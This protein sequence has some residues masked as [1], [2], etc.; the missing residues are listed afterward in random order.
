VPP[1]QARHTVS[2][3][4]RHTTSL[5]RKQPLPTAV[6]AGAL[7]G[8]LCGLSLPKADLGW[9]AWICLLPILAVV[10]CSGNDATSRRNLLLGGLTLGL[11]A[12]G[13][14]VYWIVETLG[15]Y[16]GLGPA[17]AT[18]TTC[19]LILYLALYP[20]FFT[21][22]WA[23]AWRQSQSGSGAVLPWLGA[24][25]WAILDWVQTWMLSGFPWAV[26]GTTQYRVPLISSLAAL[27]GVHGLS[28]VI[29][30]FNCGLALILVTRRQRLAG[31]FAVVAVMALICGWGASYLH[32]MSEETPDPPLRIG[33]V[34]GNI[35]QDVK[36]EPG[37]KD[38]TTEHYVD[39]SRRLARESGPIDL[40]LWPET[41]LP[42]RFDDTAHTPYRQ[43]VTQLAV[44]LDT[45]LF[46]G[47]LG[48]SAASG[49]PGLYNRAF[50]IDRHGRLAGSGDKVHL[51]PFGEYL[52]FP[53]LFD[54]M[55]G[56]TAQSGSF[57][58]GEGHAVISLAN[59]NPD[60]PGRALGLFICFE[61][62]FPSITRE[63]ASNGAQFLVNTTN[64]AWFGTTSAPYQHFAMVVLRAIE[65]G[66]TV[67]RAANTGISGAIGP[68]G[69][70]F[71]STDLFTTETLVVDVNPRTALT[72]YV[73]F[74]DTIV[75]VS[76]MIWWAFLLWRVYRRRRFVMQEIGA[77]SAELLHLSTHPVPL[78]RPLVF[79]PGYDSSTTAMATLRD[80]V[81][82]C[83]SNTAGQLVD[84]DLRHDLTLSGLIER[85]RTALPTVPCDY[86]GH[87]LGGLIGVGLVRKTDET[88]W[89][90][91]LATPF[92]GT[93]L[94]TLARW[95]RSPF[96]ATL[97]DLTANAPAL[98]ELRQ[99][100]ASQ[101]GFR[102]QRLLG[103][104]VRSGLAAPRQRT[105]HVPLLLGPRRRHQ[106]IH[107]DPRVVLDIVRALR[108]RP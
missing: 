100:A 53:A 36:W 66:R 7:S 40:I 56:L 15:S 70:V 10:L 2:G 38:T 60:L 108:G 24:A 61:S 30:A 103:D 1:P 81:E 33:I 27:V 65:T 22:L 43:A 14:R 104:P 91:A 46:V 18:A 26:L 50:L 73:R 16:G 21:R 95:L 47:S 12:S 20:M 83:F 62:N 68:D 28:F 93:H 76:A 35:R 25:T 77:A 79:L 99:Q 4:E 59:R 8:V 39:L 17:E 32:T 85:A 74:G 52:P 80:H 29:V 64:D 101:K 49:S 6:V 75:G 78:Q 34:Q 58:A 86:V 55:R 57:D 88:P 72:P 87:S 67:V 31:A 105:F 89:V 41:A 90:F 5:L 84:L 42:F 23:G 9:L 19:L 92:R 69:R 71:R 44:E 54:Y 106:A 98:V 96:P 94:A 3:L 11:V 13:F 37:W 63:L 82:R 48:T 97:K 51:V 107:A 102:A 45:P